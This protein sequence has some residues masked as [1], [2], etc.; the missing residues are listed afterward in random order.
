MTTSF[1]TLRLAEGWRMVNFGC[2]ILDAREPWPV[3]RDL[4]DEILPRVQKNFTHDT[5]PVGKHV[6]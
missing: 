6:I 5:R 1:F 2:W 4:S 3:A